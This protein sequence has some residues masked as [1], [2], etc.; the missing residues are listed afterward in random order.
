MVARSSRLVRLRTIAISYEGA[1]PIDN[2][3]C[4]VVLVAD[5]YFVVDDHTS[6]DLSA[7]DAA[8]V[9]A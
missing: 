8:F 2:G 6:P 4:L 3:Y 7:S 1:L 9:S 5:V